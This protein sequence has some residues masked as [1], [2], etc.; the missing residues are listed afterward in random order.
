MQ[1]LTVKNFGHLKDVDIELKSINIII[2][3]NGSGKSALGKLTRV[4][5]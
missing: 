1:R 3:E 5:F 2:G 4:Q